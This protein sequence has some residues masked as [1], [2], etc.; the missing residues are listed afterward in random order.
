M[1]KELDQQKSRKELAEYFGRSV[2][3]INHCVWIGFSMP[4][5]RATPR[6]LI[7][8]LQKHSQPCKEYRKKIPSDS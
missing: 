8:F 2:S 4:G 5:G 3:W 6:D 7:S 1:D